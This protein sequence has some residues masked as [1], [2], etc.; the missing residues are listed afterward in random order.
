MASIKLD[1]HIPPD[2]NP[3]SV[4]QLVSNLVENPETVFQT[5]SELMEFLSEHGGG[6]RQEIH[7]TAGEMGI[8][9]KKPGSVKL[10]PVGTFLAQIREEARADLL[11]YLMYT[12]WSEAHPTEFLQSWAYRRVCDR[13]WEMST[14]EIPA[15]ARRLVEDIINEAHATFSALPVD[16]FDDISFGTK[17][18]TGAHK[19]MEALQPEV[20]EKSG[21]EYR[22]FTRREFCPP[23]LLIMAIG[24]ILR[25]DPDA[26]ELDILLTPERR[27]ALCQICLLEPSALDRALDWALP[28]FPTVISPGT[29]AGYYGRFVRLHKRP[30]F[31][32]L[33]R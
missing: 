32:D 5:A 33:I 7:I 4:G 23:E 21:R 10:S 31:E 1:I 3:E 13:Y 14:V 25:D 27:D 20:L 15:V 24:Y 29:T 18:L 9:E 16:E 11:H 2:S 22:R 8:I 17:S 28:A 19:W 30:T 6:S 12:G 26:T